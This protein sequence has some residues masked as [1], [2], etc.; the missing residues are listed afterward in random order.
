MKILFYQ[1]LDSTMT[2]AGRLLEREALPFAVVS[3]TQTAGKGKPGR[4]WH[5][6]PGSSLLMT[7]VLPQTRPAGEYSFIAGLAVRNLLLRRCGL[8]CSLKWVNDVYCGSRKLCGIL[9]EQ[10]LRKGSPCI[11]IGVGINV[12]TREFP[13]ELKATSVL[14]EN[15]RVCAPRELAAPL[16]EEL[17]AL[18]DAPFDRIAGDWLQAMYMRGEY[19]SLDCGG[20]T[21]SGTLEGID[22]RGRLLVRTPGG[23]CRALDSG[24]F[25]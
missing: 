25:L 10:L 3:R 15:G 16:A 11:S 12:L 1:T 9:C 22:S 4:K 18:T 8:R 7:L 24:T 17:T 19:A 6:S 23:A 13:P 21:V 2:E 5:D 20:E 14:L